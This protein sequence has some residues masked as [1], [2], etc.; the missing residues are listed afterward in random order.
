ML[1][2]D[3]R[4]FKVVAAVAD[5]GV[6][7]DEVKIDI[8]DA[9]DVAGNLQVDHTAT[10]DLEVD[11]LNPTASTITIDVTDNDQTDGDAAAS[12]TVSTSDLD[13][14]T[15]HVDMRGGEYT[16][17][18]SIKSAYK[19][20]V[21]QAITDLGVAKSGAESREQ[22]L[23]TAKQ[24]LSNELDGYANSDAVG[25]EASRL[26]GLRDDYNALE[27]DADAYSDAL[28]AKDAIAGPGVDVDLHDGTVNYGSRGELLA[29]SN[30]ATEDANELSSVLNSV[31]TIDV[32]AS[33]DAGQQDGSTVDQN[34]TSYSNLVSAK[35]TADA[36]VADFFDPHPDNG[37]TIGLTLAMPVRH[38]RQRSCL[39]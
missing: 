8:T 20:H 10:V 31:D 21:N 15:I 29:D 1:G 19:Q 38:R 35:A 39:S 4:T 12:F 14:G 17:L 13:P 24:N 22:T 25:A 7:F 16:E 37:V 27:F 3:G 11:T 34:F 36:A 9:Y 6:D 23:D 26:E 32:D 2:G 5:A 18:T 30:D 33:L 28:T